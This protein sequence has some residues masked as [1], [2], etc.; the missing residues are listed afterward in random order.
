[1]CPEPAITRAGWIR[2]LI[3][4]VVGIAVLP[5]TPGGRQQWNM[6]LARIHADKLQFLRNDPRFSHVSF[7]YY[8]GGRPLGSLYVGGMVDN[9]ED[10]NALKKIV[11]E[12][13]PP[14]SVFYNLHTK[15]QRAE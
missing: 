1:L 3:I 13:N 2:I 5:F 4:T 8:S 7:D 11:T 9:D 6:H 15:G 14:V 10:K 12:S